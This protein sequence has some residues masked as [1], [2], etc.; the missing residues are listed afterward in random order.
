MKAALRRTW[1]ALCAG[2]VLAGVLVLAWPWLRVLLRLPEPHSPCAATLT[3]EDLQSSIDLGAEF[4]VNHQ[5][6]EGRFDYAYDWARGSLSSDD[7]PVR[8]A[9]ATWGLALILRHEPSAR[10]DQALDTALRFFEA[11]SVVVASK[12]RFVVYPGERS[13]STGTQALVALAVVERLAIRPLDEDR[14][15]RYA[16]LAQGLLHGLL[17][18]RRGD[19]LWPARY[20]H[21]DGSAS[22]GRSPYF[23]GEA[24]L[25]L[26]RAGRILQRTDLIEAASASAHAGWTAHVVQPRALDPDPDATKGYYQWS[27][28]AMWE[29]L[30]AGVADAEVFGSHILELADWMIDVHRTL[31][32]SR[33]TGYAMEGLA[34]AVDVARRQGDDERRAWYACVY[35]RSMRRL[36]GWQ[37]GHRL[38]SADLAR[39]DA[40]DPRV[41]GGVQG[42]AREAELRIDTV[43]HQMHAAILGL[44]FGLVAGADKP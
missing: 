14:R 1:V 19:G 18:L 36:T 6:P 23:D 3:V 27:T 2:A 24:L 39:A 28:M 12:A 34:H 5:R 41:R 21:E 8:Q 11:H 13:G 17:S 35:D 38:A 4:M 44:R 26:I 9:G 16:E 37:L 7:N 15:Q 42:S 25:A 22:G 32:R 33:N 40:R 20:R 29:L 10:V 31:D 43:Q 30:D